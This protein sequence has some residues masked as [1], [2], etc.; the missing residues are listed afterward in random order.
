MVEARWN[1]ANGVKPRIDAKKSDVEY[2]RLERNHLLW[3]AAARSKRLIPTFIVDNWKVY[4]KQSRESDQNWS[5]TSTTS[6]PTH[7]WRPK[8]WEN[9]VGKFWCIHL[10]VLTLHEITICLP[11]CKVDFKRKS[12]VAVFRSEIRSS[13]GLWFYL[14][15]GRRWSNKTGHIWFNK[16]HLKYEKNLFYFSI[17]I[18]RKK[19]WRNFFWELLEGRFKREQIEG[20]LPQ[21]ACIESCRSTLIIEG[22]ISP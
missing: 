8:N 17:K 14:K 6:N 4:A 19:I 11:W 12:L 5:I 18:W 2:V 13:T 21:D 3:A 20:S 16:L 7:F 15:N 1:S 22:H 9:L 10:L